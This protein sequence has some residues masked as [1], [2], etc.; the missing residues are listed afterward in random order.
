MPMP[1]LDSPPLKQQL[2]MPPSLA[3]IYMMA[4]RNA[5]MAMQASLLMNEQYW[6]A[7]YPI[8][9]QLNIQ[10][11]QHSPQRSVTVSPTASPPSSCHQPKP[12]KL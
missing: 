2:T 1:E 10:Q 8:F 5:A 6:N 7:A 11:H 4:Q 12:G 3:Q 9:Q